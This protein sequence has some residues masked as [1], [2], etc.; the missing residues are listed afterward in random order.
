MYSEKATKFCKIFPL[1]LT[2]V[3]TVKSKGKISKNFAAFSEYMNFNDLKF[4]KEYESNL[5][6]W[7]WEVENLF[8]I[9]LPDS[10]YWI[11]YLKLWGFKTRNQMKITRIISNSSIAQ[12]SKIY[13]YCI[14]QNVNNK[15]KKNNP[16]STAFVIDS[17]QLH[18]LSII[19]SHQ[20]CH[21]N[22]FHI[23]AH[24]RK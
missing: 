21:F 12:C 9:S 11:K 13:F 7:L 8:L 14:R 4:W 22:R 20:K 10:Y 23:V 18:N 6:V 24:W 5:P 17:C 2:T 1:L 19:F 15:W 3:H 16:G